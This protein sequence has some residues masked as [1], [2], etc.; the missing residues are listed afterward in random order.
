MTGCAIVVDGKLERCSN[1][2]WFLQGKNILQS[3]ALVG[4]RMRDMWGGGEE[5]RI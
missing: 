2:R 1:P 3:V 5:K 4:E